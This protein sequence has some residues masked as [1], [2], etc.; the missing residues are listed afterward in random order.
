MVLVFM[1]TQLEAGGLKKCD[2]SKEACKLSYYFNVKFASIKWINK[3]T[4]C[5]LF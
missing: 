3:S 1:K 5:V 2:I 4:S